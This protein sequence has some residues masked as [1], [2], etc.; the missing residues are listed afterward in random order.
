M[1]AALRSTCSTGAQTCARST[2]PLEQRLTQPWQTHRCLCGIGGQLMRSFASASQTAPASKPIN[3]GK[4]SQ[5]SFSHWWTAFQAVPTVPKVLGLAGA[6]PFIA[7]A[8][9]VAKHLAG[10]LPTKFLENTAVIQVCYGVTIVSFLGAVHWGVAMSSGLSGLAGS[11]IANEAFI[12]SVLPSLAAWP[13]ALMEPGAGATVLSVLLPSC[14]LADYT[15]RN[16]GF[17]YW[18]MGLRLPLTLLATF[19]VLLTATQHFYQEVER[20]E[21][22]KQTTSR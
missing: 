6:I 19:G 21:R 13:V 22:L 11:K 15:R 12:Y 1:Q 5:G 14:Y 17:P 20:A 7:L 9:P 10:I 18:Y 3:V 8:P 2:M 4:A 16:L